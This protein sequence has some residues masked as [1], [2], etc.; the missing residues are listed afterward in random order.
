MFVIVGEVLINATFTSHYR[1][2]VGGYE[3]VSE[4][5]RER[6]GAR[7]CINVSVL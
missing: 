7:L 4:N 1:D 5:E 3:C 6:M 2:S